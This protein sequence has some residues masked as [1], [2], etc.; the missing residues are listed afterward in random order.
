MKRILLLLA[1]VVIALCADAQNEIRVKALTAVLNDLAARTNSR[2]NLNDEMCALVKVQYPRPGAIIDG[3]MVVDTA[4]HNNEYWVWLSPGAKRM[5]LHLP[6]TP[7]IE[8]E[9]IDYGVKSVEMGL[10]YNLTLV[11]PSLSHKLESSFYIEGG[12]VAGGMMGAEV[13]LGAYIGGFNIEADAMLP[14]ASAQTIYWTGGGQAA[15]EYTY[16]P[17][18]AFGGRIGF[19]IMAG[20]S[21]RITPQVGVMYM[22]LEEKAVSQSTADPAK[23]ANSAA[24][25]VGC[26]LQY[27]VSKNFALSITP[28]YNAAI[29]KSKGFQALADVCPAI[30]KWNNGA[31]VKLAASVEF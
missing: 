13:S 4:Y 5:K 6:D 20:K 10:T 27:M 28:Q 14:M 25:T 9:F 17:S 3:T 30:S 12:F 11:L 16:K 15:M 18:L 21:I 31:G 2:Y 23:G 7:T 26:K 24:M 8:V 19:G 1:S 29:A 22:G